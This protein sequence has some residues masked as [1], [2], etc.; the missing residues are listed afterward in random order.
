MTIKS[1]RYK[2]TCLIG[3][4]F[5]GSL[6]WSVT[7]RD[8][9]SDL[10][11]FLSFVCFLMSVVVSVVLGVSQRSKDAVYRVILNVVLCLLL[12]PA[13]ILGGSLRDRLFLMRLSRFQEVTN[14]LV[15]D[16]LAK[17]SD[18]PFSA[19]ASLPPQYSDLNVLDRVFI[20]STKER[21][22]VRFAMQD[23]NALGHS[24]YMFRS[25]DN[26]VTL[27]KEYPNTGYTRVAPHWFFFSE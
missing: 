27:S 17:T 21:I 26:P 20:S 16:E 6:L 11:A 13:I 18:N 15:A 14:L 24:G 22:T 7:L 3:I 25:D 5:L 10:F 23:S 9:I 2:W 19:V 4:I 12:F 1:L 8:W